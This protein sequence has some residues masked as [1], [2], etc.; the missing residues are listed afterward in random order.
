MMSRESPERKYGLLPKIPEHVIE[1]VMQ[2][3]KSFATFMKHDFEGAREAVNQDI[4]WLRENKEFLGRAVEASINAA[5][6]LY[7]E[8]LSHND[9]V[10]LQTLLLKGQLLVLQLVNESLREQHT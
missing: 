8:K 5:L 10:S 7:G 9:W 4:E 1:E 3:V 6:E 2:E